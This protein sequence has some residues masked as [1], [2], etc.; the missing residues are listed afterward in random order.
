MDTVRT[1]MLLPKD[2][3]KLERLYSEA[4]LQMPVV[5]A[6][7][8][9]V[10]LKEEGEILA[11]GGRKGSTIL[12]VA[13]RTSRQ[14]GGLAAAVVSELVLEAAEKGITRLFLFTKP[15]NEPIFRSLGF[16]SVV[17][18]DQTVMLENRKDGL[19][20]YLESLALPDR[21]GERVGCIVA[22]ANPFTR[23]HLALVKEAA[24]RCDRVLL[25]ILSDQTEPFSPEMRMEMARA[26]VQELPN[27][28]LLPTKGYL[29]SHTTFPDYF[30]P[31]KAVGRA[32]NCL[33]D[34]TLFAERIAPRL[35]ITARFVGEEPFS[36]VT[37][38]YNQCLA[39]LLPKHGISL[40]VI[41][42]AEIDGIAV[43]ATAVREAIA[44]GDME[45]V[46]R[47]VPEASFP[48][49]AAYAEERKGRC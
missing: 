7:D 15:G 16:Y 48:I 34:V 40:F 24:A 23:G 14:G 21:T 10:L 22:H 44:A 30:Y 6:L 28:I 13:A 4:S 2:K 12:N 42:R 36:A 26:A 8:A 18:T 11:A 5:D 20:R 29:V 25:F 47:L 3:E 45:K 38:Q 35:G 32:A 27:V 49:L 43:S 46:K 9:L 1:A 37:E 19:E 41:R 17:Q 33:L 39:E 31:D